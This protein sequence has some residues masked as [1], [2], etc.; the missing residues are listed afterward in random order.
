[1][2][3][4]PCLV[5]GDAPRN[6]SD[7]SRPSFCFYAFL[8]R[9]CVS[10]LFSKD[11]W[12]AFVSFTVYGHRGQL[13]SVLNNKIDLGLHCLFALTVSF[14]VSLP[15][16]PLNENEITRVTLS[17]WISSVKELWRQNDYEMLG[18]C[19]EVNRQETATEKPNEL[20]DYRNGREIID[21]VDELLAGCLFRAVFA[22]SL[23]PIIHWR[24]RALWEVFFLLWMGGIVVL[25]EDLIKKEGELAT[26]MIP[27]AISPQNS[28]IRR[29]VSLL[30]SFN[31]LATIYRPPIRVF[32]DCLSFFLI[33]SW[34]PTQQ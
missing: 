33:A 6:Y 28:T 20:E 16:L 5:V 22:D 18:F 21:L 24:E 1:M 32:S 27:W 2:E 34:Y 19:G 10:F 29:Y 9:E 4:A 31:C 26:L 3:W 13:S 30:F 15:S 14:I 8:F 7:F 12:I 23:R 11:E 25:A 17:N